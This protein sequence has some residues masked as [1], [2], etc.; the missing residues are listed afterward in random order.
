M[1][2]RNRITKN[3]QNA[4][5]AQ[6]ALIAAVQTRVEKLKGSGTEDAPA[7]VAVEWARIVKIAST[8]GF[9]QQVALLKGGLS[10][11]ALITAIPRLKTETDKL[12]YVQAKTVEKCLKV[13]DGF[14]SRTSEAMGDYVAQVIFAALH[15]G[16]DLSLNGAQASLSR[17]VSNEGNSES[18]GTR[19]NYSPGTA[20]AQASQ[21]REV[22]RL[23]G[24]GS[25]VKGARNDVM[26]LDEKKVETLREIFA[27]DGSV[28]TDEEQ[29]ELEA[30]E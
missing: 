14:A 22:V 11:D 21:V 15:N 6:Q 12:G 24:L 28:N 8:D 5:A 26:H 16:G 4:I 13:I 2:S 3:M 25:T 17:K 29:S 7:H 9:A 18:L 30:Q 20:S 19:S 1:S 10:L 27:L 23:L